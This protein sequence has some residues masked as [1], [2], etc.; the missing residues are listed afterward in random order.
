M[1]VKKVHIENPQASQLP[2]LMSDAG[3]EYHEISCVDWPENYPYQ[4]K[5][6]FAIAHNGTAILLHF[7]VTENGYKAVA[8]TDR[9]R[10]WEDS[11]VEFFVSPC[12]DDRYYNFE[13]N[14]I[15]KMHIACGVVDTERPMAPQSV[16]DLVS[17]WSSLGA[18]P[19]SEPHEGSWEYAL[20]IPVGAFYEDGITS[21]DGRDMTANFY[22]CGDLLPVPHFLSWAPI[23]LPSPRFHCPQFFGAIHFEG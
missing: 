9:G 2:Q 4:P 5:V 7:K 22:K 17:R 8:A 3:V 10:V 19:I 21:L 13:S 15:G 12:S 6:Q 14:C 16:F 23:D 1:K 11:C 20:V 18:A